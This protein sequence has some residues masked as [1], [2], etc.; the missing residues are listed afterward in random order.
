MD[1]FCRYEPSIGI[2]CLLRFLLKHVWK[3]YIDILPNTLQLIRQQEKSFEVR[4]GSN[5]QS[6]EEELTNSGHSPGA[7]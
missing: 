4:I 1:C 6:L 2:L 7:G 3:Q 5:Q